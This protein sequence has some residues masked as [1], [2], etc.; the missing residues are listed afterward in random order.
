MRQILN[1][2]YTLNNSIYSFNGDGIYYFETTDNLEEGYYLAISNNNFTKT[3]FSI[4]A[5]IY[6]AKKSN[7]G[8]YRYYTL[9][10]ESNNP[11]NTLNITHIIPIDYYDKLLVVEVGANN[12]VDLVK[13]EN[14][15]I[16]KLKNIVVEGYRYNEVK[17]TGSNIYGG[18]QVIKLYHTIDLNTG[19]SSAGIYYPSLPSNYFIP[20]IITIETK[21]YDLESDL[22][23][24]FEESID[25]GNTWNTIK[26]Y[27]TKVS[28][29]YTTYRTII[30][31]SQFYNKGIQQR[32]RVQQ[33]NLI[34]GKLTL[35]YLEME[36][37]Y[38]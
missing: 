31:D 1:F 7:S 25:G 12:L 30:T 34:F 8:G 22:I 6:L 11:L 23:L 13:N 15:I 10:I 33:P 20:K 36:N 3:G 4:S 28:N 35:V 37:Y 24:Y 5:V 29:N 38:I 16:N 18:N 26:Q 17:F 9:N 32:L 2:N 27:N 21:S 14:L 19:L